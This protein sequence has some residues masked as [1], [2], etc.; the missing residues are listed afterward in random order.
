MRDIFWIV[1]ERLVLWKN[2]PLQILF[3]IGIP[4][5]SV[6]LYLFAYGDQETNLLTI[7]VVDQDR[8][9]YSE[10][11]IESL[12]KR[13]SVQEIGSAEEIDQVLSRQNAVAV[14]TIPKGYQEN[15]SENTK[16]SLRTFQKGELLENIDR[17]TQRALAEV[18]SIHLLAEAGEEDESLE[19]LKESTEIEINQVDQS[20]MT[21]RMS[22]QIVGFLLM[23]LLFQAGNFGTTTIQQERRN[24]IYTRLMTT[25]V[26]KSTYFI[27][28]TIFATFA[29]LI[30]VMLAVV[31]MI[32]LFNI[33]PGLSAV[34]LIVLLSLF[35]LLAVSWSIAIGV[36]APST[37]V[38]AALQSI[39][40]T[41]TSL[42]S[43]ALIPHEVMPEL[44]Q[45]VSMV[46]PQYW[47]L[48]IIKNFQSGQTWGSNYSEVII[49][50]IYTLLFLSLAVYGY[51]R[52]TRQEV[53]S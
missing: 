5:L 3:L 27:G 23:M 20:T 28:T 26:A 18:S 51:T 47:I 1:R 17:L 34:D 49:L 33:D 39:L 41:V 16:L 44:M 24:K 35:S 46:T 40:I 2:R 14:I 37:T 43:G 8:S 22:V 13:V 36:L 6:V 9:S 21:E 45:K 15:V 19:R 7:G 42:L 48:T 29:M 38:A 32:V 10:L 12:E 25:S 53:Y 30:Q 52:R 50:A 4:F 11:L 31:V